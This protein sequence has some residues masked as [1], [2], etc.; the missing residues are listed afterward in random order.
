MARILILYGT[1]EGHTRAIARAMAGTLAARGFGAELVEAGQANPSPFEY[2]GVIVAASVHGGSYQ[3]AVVHWVKAHAAEFGTRPTAFVSSCL[4][5]NA[6]SDAKVQADIEAIV[7]RFL[8][9]TGWEPSVVKHV[10]GALLYTQYNVFTRWIMKRIV[11]SQHGD[12]DT[13]RDYDYTDWA[14]VR[15]FAED[16]SHRFAAAAA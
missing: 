4:A 10:A 13:S 9:A 14:D 2:D 12:V 11:A 15:A 6:R 3:R 8:D 1:T 16:F 5:V 7:K